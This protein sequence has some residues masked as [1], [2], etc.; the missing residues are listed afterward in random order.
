VAVFIGLAIRL[1]PPMGLRRA[2]DPSESA[3]IQLLRP[4]LS[5]GSA[6]SGRCKRGWEAEG[7]H[8]AI[9]QF[10]PPPSAKEGPSGEAD[11]DQRG[12]VNVSGCGGVL[13]GHRRAAIP[14]GH[15]RRPPGVA[16]EGHRIPVDADQ[17]TSVAYRRS[18][19]C[20]DVG[21]NRINPHRPWP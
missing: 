12:R 8:P 2:G 17:R 3:A 4:R 16:G 11:A 18:M 10:R 6:A 14:A 7:D 5:I 20:G 9:C 21:A 1:Y 15:Q 13:L 19:R